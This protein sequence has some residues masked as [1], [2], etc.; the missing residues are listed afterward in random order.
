MAWSKKP[1]GP[2]YESVAAGWAKGAFHPVYLFAGPDALLKE[3]ALKKFQEAF[4][5]K[6]ADPGLSVDRFDGETASAG[7][8]LSALKTFSLLGDKRL[9]LVRRAQ[10]LAPS[11]TNALA[12]GLTGLPEGNSLLLLWEE[13][14][15]E[16]SVLVQAVK[17]AGI[18]L[19]FWAPFENQLPRWVQ[20]RARS[21]NKTISLET[22]GALIDTVGAALPDL[23]QALEILSLYAKD[24]PGLEPR[25]LEILQ[26]ET[27]SLQFLEFDRAFWRRDKAKALE[28]ARLLTAQGQ[29]PVFVLPQ[30]ARVYRKL[31][32]AKAM[33]A[34]KKSLDDVWQQVRI[35]SR[36]PQREFSEALSGH[37][38]EDLLNAL[39]TIAEA[40]REFK[41]GRREG[42]AGLT[43]V[44]YCI[45]EGKKL[46]AA[47]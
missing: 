23:A 10:E 12:D 20:D 40:E 6:G 22:A 43:A 41:T 39:E 9:V 28:L 4:L 27:R 3:E 44:I 11:E 5:G 34:E 18:V 13:R 42:D 21:L 46:L 36:E 15:D 7:Q 47:G 30:L 37:S 19:T 45:L 35:K 8:I 26:T 38:W 25:D 24:R 17:S 1:S 31:F 33:L 16:R 14:A 32:M 2:T 29:E